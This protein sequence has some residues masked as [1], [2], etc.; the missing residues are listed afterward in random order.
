VCVCVCVC[1]AQDERVGEDKACSAVAARFKLSPSMVTWAPPQTLCRG[2]G[3]RGS[4]TASEEGDRAGGVTVGRRRRRGTEVRGGREGGGGAGDFPPQLRSQSPAA[5]AA[6]P[7][8]E[9][10]AGGGGGITFTRGT[11]EIAKVDL[12][13]LGSRT[14]RLVKA[15]WSPGQVST[16]YIYV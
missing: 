6:G 15:A 16:V 7:C 4:S 12:S 11:L 14:A 9:G 1:A 5:S 13:N 3:G 2:Q 10:G 8:G